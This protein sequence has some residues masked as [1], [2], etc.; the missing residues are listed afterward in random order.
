[1][2]IPNPLVITVNSVAKSLPKINQDNYGSEY[3]L[4]EA[5]EDYRVKIRHS[6]E[7]A[8]KNGSQLERHNVE[9]TRTI[10]A[11]STDER[12]VV[13]QTYTV[14]RCEKSSDLT[15]LGHTQAAL[16]GL[17]TAGV[18]SDLAGWQN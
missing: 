15:K 7:A 4:R 1:M 3:Y 11:A 5:T 6:K 13:L 8:Q 10:F 14:I 9:L 12:D 16:N 17:L 18:V 2:S